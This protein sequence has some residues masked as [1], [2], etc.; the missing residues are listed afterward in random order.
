M[1]PC[2]VRSPPEDLIPCLTSSL[3]HGDGRIRD[4]A[5]GPCFELA[6]RRGGRRVHHQQVAEPFFKHNAEDLRRSNR[7]LQ[8]NLIPEQPLPRA[9]KVGGE[10]T[11]RQTPSCPTHWAA[12]GGQSYRQNLTSTSEG[13]RA[14]CVVGIIVTTVSLFAVFST[15]V[16]VDAWAP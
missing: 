2:I 15:L 7:S 4:V 6:E 13:M 14:S 5:E 16:L 1:L 10:R 12:F 11:C 9:A 3:H 8:A